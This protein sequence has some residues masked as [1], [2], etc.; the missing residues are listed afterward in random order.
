VQTLRLN[1]LC[2][3]NRPPLRRAIS[4]LTDRLQHIKNSHIGLQPN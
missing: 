1:D 2:N 4:R 3:R